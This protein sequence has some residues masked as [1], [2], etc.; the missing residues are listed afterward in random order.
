[1]AIVAFPLDVFQ[2]GSGTSTNMNA[3]EVIADLTGGRAHPNDHV[4]LGQSSNDVMPTAVQL[5]A[6]ERLGSGLIPALDDLARSLPRAHELVDVVKPGRTH[7]MDAVPTTLGAELA[8]YAEQVTESVE[9]LRAALRPLSRVP[10]GGTAVGTGLGADP[11]FADAVVARLAGRGR[12]PVPVSTPHPRAARMGGHDALVAAS[13]ALDVVSSALAKIADDLRWMSSGPTGGLG[14][15]QLPKLQ[16]GSSIMPGKVNPVVPE[17]VL[18]VCVQ[19]MGNHV[20]VAAA[21]SRGNLEL[22]V[23][24]P[25]MARNLLTSI[26]LL[27]AASGSLTRD[28][29]ARFTVDVD[30]LREAASRSPAIATALNAELGYDRVERI[31]RQAIATGSTIRDAALADGVEAELYDRVVDLDAVAHGRPGNDEPR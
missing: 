26:D 27:T 8:A 13:A 25:V 22:N 1:M 14:E 19:V 4:N 15:L 23:M 28:C 30:G 29:V 18:Q 6:A 20:A 9:F 10:L 7:L 3:N 16:K 12:L 5:A 11:R 21:G 31:V 2:T 24:L 17:V